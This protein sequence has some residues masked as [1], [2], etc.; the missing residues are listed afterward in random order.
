M[1]EGYSIH[2]ILETKGKKRISDKELL[3]NLSSEVIEENPKIIQDCRENPKAIEALIGRVMGKTR[4]QA[5]PHIARKIIVELL[6][7]IGII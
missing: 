5:D 4:G 7:E 6:K 1:M 3:R 2:E